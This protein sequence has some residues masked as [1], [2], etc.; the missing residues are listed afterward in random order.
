[1]NPVTPV[2]GFE[3][4]GAKPAQ[5]KGELDMETFM[6]LLVV[7]LVNQSWLQWELGLVNPP[8]GGVFRIPP[9]GGTA[10]DIAA[11]QLVLP[12]GVAVDSRGVHVTGPVFGPGRIVRIQ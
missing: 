12:A 6:R 2:D 10:V 11:G 5:K 1:M 9:G 8:I 4:F 7:Q 3:Y